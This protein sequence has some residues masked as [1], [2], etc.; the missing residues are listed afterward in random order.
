MSGWRIHVYRAVLMLLTAALMAL[1]FGFSSQDRDESGG[2]SG[3]I[4]LPVTQFIASF[5]DSITEAEMADLYEDVDNAIR[6]C[7]HFAEYGCLGVLLFLILDSYGCRKGWIPWLAATLYAVTDEIHQLYS[8]GRSCQVK[9]ILVDSLGAL[10]GVA[11]VW[12]IMKI[13]RKRRT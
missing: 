7:A 8:P 2:M 12:L 10:T 4:A 1:I 3:R 13:C 6:K 11:G 9:D 5:R